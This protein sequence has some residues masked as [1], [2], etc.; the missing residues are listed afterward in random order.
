M[1]IWSYW[2]GP[3]NPLLDLCTETL[4]KHNPTAKVVTPELL[5][6]MGGGHILKHTEGVILPYR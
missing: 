1:N 2:E 6:E 3:S 4:C 5:E